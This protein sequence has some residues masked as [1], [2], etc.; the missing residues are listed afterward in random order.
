MSN[1]PL[2]P[3]FLML[4]LTVS[5]MALSGCARSRAD[6]LRDRSARVEQKLMSERDRILADSAAADR[7]ARMSHLQTLRLG[8]SVVNVSI[9]TVPLMLT[10]EDQRT[11]GYSVLDET[12]GTI[13][14]NIPI[15]GSSSAGQLRPYP[16]LFSPQTGLNYDAIRRG[17]TPSGIAR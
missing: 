2:A 12:I 1:R 4:L 7:E 3:S 15:Y 16:S 9:V 11:I 10:T 17:D 6:Q 8:L 14:W 5:A 13:D